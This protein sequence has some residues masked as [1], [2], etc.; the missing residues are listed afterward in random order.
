[1]HLTGHSLKDNKTYILFIK[2]NR[3]LSLRIGRGLFCIFSPG[4]YIYIGSAKK[5]LNKRVLRHFSKKKKFHWH[6]D[7]FLAHTK[8]EFVYVG[9]IDEKEI[10]KI[11]LDKIGPQI[12]CPG[13]GAS[14]SPHPSHLFLIKDEGAIIVL[15]ENLG[16]RRYFPLA[17]SIIQ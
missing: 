10:V 9:P 11:I 6:I 13:F 12:P 7:Y 2:N 5:N 8:V 4:R 1:V 15:L 17:R 16:F 14:D 3:P